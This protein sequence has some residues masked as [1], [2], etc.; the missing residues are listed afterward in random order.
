MDSY[1]NYP[2]SVV[3]STTNNILPIATVKL[4]TF[5]EMAEEFAS[6]FFNILLIAA[7]TC[8]FILKQLILEISNINLTFD[9]QLIILCICIYTL[10]SNTY[11]YNKRSEEL[12]EINK[13]ITSI[14]LTLDYLDRNISDLKKGEKIRDQRYES[15][16]T[17]LQSHHQ[18]TTKKV[19]NF[20]SLGTMLK[21]QIKKLDKELNQYN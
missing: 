1:I 10:L 3:V 4:E 8:T 2:A 15:V 13:K 14:E 16:A 5:Y 9:A 18:E 12:K 19:E 11:A 21:K 6:M 20:K 7:Y 17:K